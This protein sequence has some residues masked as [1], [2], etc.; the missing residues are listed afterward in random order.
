[1]HAF[2]AKTAILQS[3][4]TASPSPR[5]RALLDERCGG[6]RTY[7]CVPRP[8]AHIQEKASEIKGVQDRS[9][10]AR[11]AGSKTRNNQPCYV[12]RWRLNGETSTY[13]YE[14]QWE[15]RETKQWRT[16]LHGSER[17]GMRSLVV[18]TQKGRTVGRY[19]CL[20]VILGC[21]RELLCFFCPP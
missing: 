21:R 1:M 4:R 2:L 8:S 7:V 9:G 5:R 10:T 20:T 16:L 15:E 19:A 12:L 6:A 11:R 17:D 3:N 13:T 14:K 18:K